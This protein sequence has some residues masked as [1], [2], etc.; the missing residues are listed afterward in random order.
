MDFNRIRITTLFFRRHSDVLDQAGERLGLGCAREIAI[1]HACSAADRRRSIA[2]DEDGNR[3]VHWARTAGDGAKVDEFPPILGMRAGPERAHRG[4]VLVGAR[5]TPLPRN[6]ERLEL[7]TH[8][9][10]AEAEHDPALGQTVECRQLLGQNERVSLRHDQDAG[11][12]AQRRCGGADIGEPDKGIRNRRISFS[13]RRTILGVGV[14]RFDLVGPND[15][16]AAPDR[17]EAYGLGRPANLKRR[18]GLGSHTARKCQSKFHAPHSP[19]SIMAT[20]LR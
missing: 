2:A 16:F 18:F 8:P 6:A 17:V 15:V 3:A 5:T 7:L 13:R 1:G 14:C 10:D 9:A 20:S 11:S 19:L 12:Q 4:H